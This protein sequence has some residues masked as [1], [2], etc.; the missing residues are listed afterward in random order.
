MSGRFC[1]FWLTYPIVLFVIEFLI[2]KKVPALIKDGRV[3][4]IVMI[5]LVACVTFGLLRFFP[6]DAHGQNCDEQQDAFDWR[7]RR[8]RHPDDAERLGNYLAEQ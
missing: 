4:A 3:F 5:I 8:V 2:I 7:R 1:L 6:A